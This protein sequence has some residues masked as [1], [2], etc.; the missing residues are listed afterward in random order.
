ME[1]RH[2]R[3]IAAW[4]GLAALAMLALGLPRASAAD[5]FEPDQWNMTIIDAPE[6]WVAGYLGE[7]ATVAVVD[8]GVDKDHPELA[9]RL[10]PGASWVDCGA[11][12][13]LPCFGP[14]AWDDRNGHGTHVAG[15]VGAP[16]DGV[17]VTGVAPRAR[18]LPVRVLDEN[19]DGFGEDIAA[20]IDWAVAN[21]ADV[22]NLSLGMSPGVA[23]AA[24]LT[25]LDGGI[26]EAV[27]RAL[28]AG[29]LV[30]TAAGNDSFPICGHETFRS[31]TP[32]CVG[33]TGFLD[34]P[35]WYSNWGVGIDVVAPGGDGAVFCDFDVLSTYPIDKSD[36]C[37]PEGY[38]GLSG[39]SMA[40][41]HVSGIAALLVATGSYD[42][43]AAGQRIVATAEGFGVPDATPLVG[44]PRVNARLALGL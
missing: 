23:T 29:V 18:I 5:D 2:P 24:A 19:G 35:A 9:A 17:G 8:S 21:G 25:G 20:G 3:T 10:L 15:I 32:L 4:I 14:D 36:A 12:V 27:R 1:R 6:A 42:P 38:G 7:G 28:G 44:P 11:A 13:P 30:V 40:A 41:P 16:R 39:T 22:I 31:D 26:A 33:A 34:Q 43:I 37:G